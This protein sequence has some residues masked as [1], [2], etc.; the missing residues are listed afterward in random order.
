MKGLRAV[1]A[2]RMSAHGECEVNYVAVC[3]QAS[4]LT[5]WTRMGWE[6]RG[7]YAV[8]KG[9]VVDDGSIL[10]KCIRAR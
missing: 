7:L 8:M 9:K 4:A 5:R 3:W 10:F 1:R 6:A 2:V